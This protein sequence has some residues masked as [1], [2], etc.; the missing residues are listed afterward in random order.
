MKIKI[1]DC[2]WRAYDVYEEWVNGEIWRRGRLAIRRIDVI[3][4]ASFIF[5]VSYY[6]I[7]SGP[8]GALQ[9]GALFVLIA[10]IA[11]WML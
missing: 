5:C 10:F 11:M 9:G 1:P 8:I 6:W 7:T 2:F 4:L 3:L